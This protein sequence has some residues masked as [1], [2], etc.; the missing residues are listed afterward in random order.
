LL[1]QSKYLASSWYCILVGL[2]LEGV[3]PLKAWLEKLGQLEGKE[4]GWGEGGIAGWE[5]G[6]ARNIFGGEGGEEE[7]LGWRGLGI[8]NIF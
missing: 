1:D 5:R 7:G 6:V 3:S 2:Y 8:F 4:G